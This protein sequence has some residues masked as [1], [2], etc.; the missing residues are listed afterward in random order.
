MMNVP[1]QG[2][3]A[4]FELKAGSVV[5]N[6]NR[7]PVFEAKVAKKV[8]LHDQ[9]PVLVAQENEVVSVDNVNGPFISVGSMKEVNTSG[10]WPTTYGNQD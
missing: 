1:I 9:D 6:N 2:V 8:I 3:D 5:K 10:N 4:K 7:I